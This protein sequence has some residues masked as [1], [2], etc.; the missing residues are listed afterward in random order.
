MTGPL[1]IER[2]RWQVS[3]QAPGELHKKT[4]W[5]SSRTN[6]VMMQSS[7]TRNIS[8]VPWSAS[9][10]TTSLA[11]PTHPIQSSSMMGG[12]RPC[13][14]WRGADGG[15]G[16]YEG[17]GGPPQKRKARQLPVA[18]TLQQPSSS[19]TAI[20]NSCTLPLMLSSRLRS[21]TIPE[22]PAGVSWGAAW[23]GGLGFILSSS[24]KSNSH[25]SH[26]AF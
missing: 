3:I 4:R 12:A 20:W 19:R 18:L 8:L 5:S 25:N 1:I 13:S 26:L 16:P 10:A 14:A 21:W 22:G 9:V 24:T 11:L 23:N 17:A 15:G 6:A 7:P 2:P